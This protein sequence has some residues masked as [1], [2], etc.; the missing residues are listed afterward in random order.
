MYTLYPQICKVLPSSSSCR[1]CFILGRFRIGVSLNQL[2]MMDSYQCDPL[3]RTRHPL[4]FALF[5]G[6]RVVFFYCPASG[7]H[8]IIILFI[9]LGLEMMI[10]MKNYNYFY[11]ISSSSNKI[12]YYII[13]FQL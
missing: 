6:R 13:I 3:G 12:F 11:I 8:H 9:I 5:F 4:L 10:M 2:F 1:T 7:R